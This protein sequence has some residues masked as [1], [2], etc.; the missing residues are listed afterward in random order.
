MV[1]SASLLIH[2]VVLFEAHVASIWTVA[3]PDPLFYH[4][5]CVFLECDWLLNSLE[6]SHLFV[7]GVD[8]VISIVKDSIL[9][10]VE[11]R[12]RGH[13]SHGLLN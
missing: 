3:I 8:F 6:L 9:S 2:L 4:L 11:L 13:Y 10:G 12:R 5:R 1:G 7:N